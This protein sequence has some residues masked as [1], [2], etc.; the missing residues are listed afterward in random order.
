MNTSEIES[1]IKLEYLLW[2]FL[3]SFS[4]G[5]LAD[6][7]PSRNIFDKI[8][9]FLQK[10]VKCLWTKIYHYS[11]FNIVMQWYRYLFTFSTISAE[12]TEKPKRHAEKIM[13]R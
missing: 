1:K 7:N 6:L 9:F 13:P 2:K 12:A 11:C 3:E 5:W 8:E 4:F 10:N